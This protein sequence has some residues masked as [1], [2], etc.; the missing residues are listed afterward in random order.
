M[1]K[2][3]EPQLFMTPYSEENGS[4]LTNEVEEE[5]EGK[6]MYCKLTTKNLVGL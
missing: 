4:P 1:K 2:F 6:A 5:E 3:Y